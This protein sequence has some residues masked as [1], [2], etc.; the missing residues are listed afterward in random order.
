MEPKRIERVSAYVSSRVW[1]ADPQQ[2]KRSSPPYKRGIA[3]WV[4]S[5]NKLK[6]VPILMDGFKW[7]FRSRKGCPFPMGCP[8]LGVGAPSGKREATHMTV[9]GVAW[10]KMSELGKSEEGSCSGDRAAL[11]M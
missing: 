7:S 1:R 4:M 9:A 11:L 6:E 5:P 8:E 2:V 10:H 3:G